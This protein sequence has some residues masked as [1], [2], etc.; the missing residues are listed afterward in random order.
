MQQLFSQP[1]Y[2]CWSLYNDLD[3][4]SLFLLAYNKVYLP[5]SLCLPSL[6][7]HLFPSHLDRPRLALPRM[8]PHPLC[9]SFDLHEQHQSW[10]CILLPLHVYIF[11]SMPLRCCGNTQLPSQSIEEHLA[12][13]LDP[14]LCN[15]STYT[16]LTPI[17]VISGDITLGW[18]QRRLDEIQMD[19]RA[20]QKS[21]TSLGVDASQTAVEDFCPKFRVFPPVL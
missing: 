18:V 12:E 8:C 5:R 3:N 14:F 6:F 7:L 20:L 15:R 11:S 10:S 2:G 4:A 19:F 21:W 17:W 1:I 16:S 13:L 9:L